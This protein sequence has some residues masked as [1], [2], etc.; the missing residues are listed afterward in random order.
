MFRKQRITQWA[1]GAALFIWSLDLPT[2]AHAGED[3]KPAGSAKR[4]E[5]TMPP[6]VKLLSFDEL[7]ARLSDGKTRLLDCRPRSDYEA[8][9]VPGA[10]WVDAKGVEAMAA[11]P[12]ALADAALWEAWLAPLGIAP[13][14]DV[15]CYDSNRQLDAARIWFLLRYLG[16]DEAGLVNGSFPLWQK[17][18]R[19]VGTEV[20]RVPPHPRAVV[21]KKDRLADRADVLGALAD[22]SARIL[23]ARSDAEH[24]GAE[25]RSRQAGRVPEA[26]HLEWKTLVDGDGRFLSAPELRA[27]VSAA[28]IKPGEAVIT[29]CQGGGRASVNAFALELLGIRARNY[30]LG[31]SDWGNADS[32]PIETGPPKPDQAP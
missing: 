27:K 17:E 3:A 4:K 25:K 28:G 2:R 8:G 32:V 14:M 31:W 20:T 24:L 29:H 22:K 19:P 21:F 10:V 23:D 26:C 12:G 7:A 15:F 30:Y 13:G 11:K 18:N 6:R 5:E 16:V 1:L 9:H